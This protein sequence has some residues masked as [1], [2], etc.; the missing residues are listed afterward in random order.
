MIRVD[1]VQVTTQEIALDLGMVEL[2]PLLIQSLVQW[3]LQLKVI[4]AKSGT[5]DIYTD[6]FAGGESDIES[7][8]DVVEKV[9]HSSNYIISNIDLTIH[10][11]QTSHLFEID[12]INSFLDTTSWQFDFV[13]QV[14][15]ILDKVHIMF[16]QQTPIHLQDFTSRVYASIEVNCGSTSAACVAP[17]AINKI[18]GRLD[19]WID[20]VDAFPQ[21]VQ[22]ELHDTAIN[23]KDLTIDAINTNLIAQRL[24]D[25]STSLPTSIAEYFGLWKLHSPEVRLSYGNT[26]YNLTDIYFKQIQRAHD[27]LF[28]VRQTVTDPIIPLFTQLQPQLAS[29]LAL[30]PVKGKLH[31]LQG[32]ISLDNPTDISAEVRL[33]D[34]SIGSANNVQLQASV[35]EISIVVANKRAA[36]KMLKPKRLSLLSP[37]ISNQAFVFNTPI[38]RINIDWNN[39]ELIRF[40]AQD[41]LLRFHRIPMLVDMHY[42]LGIAEPQLSNLL[43]HVTFDNL[44]LSLKDSI[45][46]YQLLPDNI[47]QT[48]KNDVQGTGS[49]SGNLLVFFQPQKKNNAVEFAL[50]LTSE[51][52]KSLSIAG[53]PEIRDFKG[54]LYMDLFGITLNADTISVARSTARN[55]H[56]YVDT[57]SATMDVNGQIEDNLADLTQLIDLVSSDFASAV[58]TKIMTD[59]LIHIDFSFHVPLHTTD[60]ASPDRQLKYQGDIT[61][62]DNILYHTDYADF[63]IVDINGS[64]RISNQ[65]MEQKQPFTASLD[66]KPVLFDINKLTVQ[67]QEQE[68]LRFRSSFPLPS[69]I[70]N[71]LFALQVPFIQGSTAVDVLLDLDATTFQFERLIVDSAMQGLQADIPL[72]IGKKADESVATQVVLEKRADDLFIYTE[73]EDRI[74]G[75]V[76]IDDAHALTGWI[77]M[78]NAAKQ[79]IGV[80]EDFLSIIAAYDVIDVTAIIDW[81]EHNQ[82]TELLTKNQSHTSGTLMNNISP[83][84]DTP[85]DEEAFDTSILD[86]FK[87]YFSADS[88]GANNFFTHQAEGKLMKEAG[89]WVTDISSDLL[90][91]RIFFS[92]DGEL[93]KINVDKLVIQKYDL[94]D[95][96]EDSKKA[97]AQ[98]AIDPLADFDPRI[99][100][101]IELT[102]KKLVYAGLDHG[103]WSMKL[104]PEP[105]GLRLSNLH[106]FKDNVELNGSAFWQYNPDAEL[107]KRQSTTAELT[108]SGTDI[109]GLAKLIDSKTGLIE[110]TLLWPASPVG[111]T[112]DNVYGDLLINFEDGFI[113]TETKAIALLN[114]IGVLSLDT[115][116]NVLSLDFSD[117]SNIQ[118]DSIHGQL[119][120]EDGVVTNIEPFALIGSTLEIKMA[121]TT[122]LVN[123]ELAQTL[124]I[125]IPLSKSL[126]LVSVLAGA[127][128]QISVMLLIF[129]YIFRKPLSDI[130]SARFTVSGPLDNPKMELDKVLNAE[131][132][133]EIKESS[134]DSQ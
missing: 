69:G 67:E 124:V 122:D 18:D 22:L 1:Q 49:I 74:K 108:L 25:D 68:L 97:P 121:G 29:E 31:G 21:Q 130:T 82:L 132:G 27:I 115:I 100:K 7:I 94:P 71:R 61:L 105:D 110:T 133:L 127:A 83:P 129:N 26:E 76:L 52:I 103:Q 42:D 86:T 84:Q 24:E 111:F 93:Q 58:P 16:D 88:I 33:T 62:I 15:G 92:S 99:E 41:M 125:K 2:Q 19:M 54:N 128:P 109:K 48:I 113:N 134:S 38:I 107:G 5:I 37:L 44:L 35:D 102:I 20:F 73:I 23:Y 75:A 10:D 85:E 28:S 81:F 119:Q 11:Q 96:T 57:H 43:L 40:D 123:K 120:F 50:T 70:V 17:L 53:Y 14:P 4:R 66:N 106:A 39:P 46:P 89:S 32:F 36:V 63:P 87:I 60:S 51:E 55:L 64:F 112:I 126:P 117:K 30:W 8:V 91:S 65:G 6:Q 59:G 104:V 118:F 13:G 98:K 3:S 116:I 95:T 79:P 47:A 45:V 77:G 34:V 72:G 101:P 131:S 78:G 56:L 12:T 9:I 90:S 80:S 114:L